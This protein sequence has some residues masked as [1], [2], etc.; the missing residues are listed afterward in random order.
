M[1]K[2]PI[3]YLDYTWNPI[4]MRCS[5]ISAGCAHCWHLRMAN[6]MAGMK[7]FPPEVRA[8][9]AG[10]GPPVLVEHRLG[11]PLRR[12][13]S[14][15]I[16][17]QF[18]GDLMH[19]DIPDDFIFD[20]L[21]TIAKCPWHTFQLLIK[22]PK[23]MAHLWRRAGNKAYPNLWLGVSAENQETAD[24]RIPLLLQTPAALR[25]VSC[26]PMLEKVELDRQVTIGPHRITG[27][28]VQF[29]W[30]NNGWGI[31]WVIC[32]AETGPGARP[33]HP[34]WARSLRDQAREAGVPFFMKQMSGKALIPDDLMI[35]EFPK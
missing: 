11:E 15:R 25:F 4:A 27:Q 35:R 13:K 20:V 8:A 3:E 14:A 32:G 7:H 29:P 1:N 6:R 18:M 28:S 12:K 22:R 33:M 31:D 19:K 2:T 34:D 30:L 24:E 5:P 16:G 21:T 10:E 26:E 23:R 9:Y 17:T